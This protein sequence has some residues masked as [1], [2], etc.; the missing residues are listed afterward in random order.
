MAK[1]S[2][3]SEA[4]READEKLKAAFDAGCDYWTANP[5]EMMSTVHRHASSIYP[6]AK[7]LAL[8]FAFGYARAREKHDEYFREKK[9]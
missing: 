3:T 4:Q 1:R 6:D 2:K 8:E 9:K 7:E 5:D